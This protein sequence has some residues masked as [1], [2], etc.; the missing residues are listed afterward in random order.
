MPDATLAARVVTAF[1][2]LGFT[3]GE[4]VGDSFS[5]EAAPSVFQQVF[6]VSPQLG[7]DGRMR[8]RAKKGVRAAAKPLSDLPADKLPETLRPLVKGVI[9]SEPPAFGPGTIP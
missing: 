4:V 2:A 9:F 3:C 6:G 1:R 5:I 8:E 7:P